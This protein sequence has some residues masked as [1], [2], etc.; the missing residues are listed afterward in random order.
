MREAA[1]RRSTV[2]GGSAALD[3]EHTRR[4]SKQRRRETVRTVFPHGWADTPRW[5]REEA[6]RLDDN[7][8]GNSTV[9]AWRRWRWPHSV[10]GTE[11]RG[12]RLGSSGGMQRQ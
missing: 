5:M 12:A 4:R 10:T 7:V 2:S 11:P 3:S 8:K 1:R 9:V 6:L